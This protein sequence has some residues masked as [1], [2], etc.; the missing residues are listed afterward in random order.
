MD[1]FKPEFKD[2]PK[3][4]SDSFVVAYNKLPLLPLKDMVILS[5]TIMPINIGRLVSLR[6][7][8]QALKGTSTLFIT[9]QKD[10][11]IQK[12]TTADDLYMYGTRSQILEVM[13]LP[14]GG[15]KILVEGICRAK[16]TKFDFNPDFI[17]VE[18][19]DLPTTNLENNAEIK[20]IWGQLS[21]LYNSYVKLNVSAP[22]ELVSMVKT[23]Q[24]MDYV[25]DAV[26][27]RIS[28][29]AFEARQK[30]LELP[31]LKERMLM[32][33]S[34]LANEIEILSEEQRLRALVQE[35]EREYEQKKT[36]QKEEL[37]C[38]DISEPLF[39]LIQ[40]N[41]LTETA[42]KDL[43]AEGIDINEPNQ[44]G[45]YALTEAI[46]TAN[47]DMVK[48]LLDFGANTLRA[49]DEDGETPFMLAIRSED[50]QLL[51]L[52]LSKS[53]DLYK[54]EKH[55]ESFDTVQYLAH[56]RELSG[57]K[58]IIIQELQTSAEFKDYPQL[59]EVMKTVTYQRLA[60]DV[61]CYNTEDVIEYAKLEMGTVPKITVEYFQTF[62]W[63]YANLKLFLKCNVSLEQELILAFDE[64]DG[65]K[66]HFITDFFTPLFQKLKLDVVPLETDIKFLV[67]LLSR[68]KQVYLNEWEDH[69]LYY[70]FVDGK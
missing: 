9:A 53:A 48:L 23:P 3:D 20:A 16:V 5:K 45:L 43:I 11:A 62:N 50:M 69:C 41:Q 29:L 26:V 32:V 30:V 37:E 28:N 27:N 65:D 15:F 55:D 46:K 58:E 44:D 6:A 59:L 52:L 31:D 68:K 24:D 42:L 57:I 60:M 34:L 10:L 2:L 70:E 12:P 38:V 36:I 7:V 49:V 35:L 1:E 14:N 51:D 39:D 21:T 17:E 33:S 66:T 61:N 13:P 8:E 19:E 56:E 47:R 40:S 63:S 54:K 18:Y 64:S 25:T 22:A 4:T 67:L